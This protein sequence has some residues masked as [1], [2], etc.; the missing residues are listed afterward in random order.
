MRVRRSA[1][2]PHL[3]SGAGGRAAPLSIASCSVTF[4]CSLVGT[5]QLVAF[6]FSHHPALVL[7]AAAR[8]PRGSLRFLDLARVCSRPA[9]RRYL[10]DAALF[11]RGGA[12]APRISRVSVRVFPTIPPFS[13]GC[14]GSPLPALISCEIAGRGAV[15]KRRGAVL[16]RSGARAPRLALCLSG[17]AFP[18]F[19]E[20]LDG[21]RSYYDPGTYLVPFHTCCCGLTD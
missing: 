1:A 3:L 6:Y 9:G 5:Q 17:R 20:K 21:G 13:F 18:I 12:I 8:V 14:R 10:G 11:W 16:A 15:F 2:S 19:Y 7:G 4:R